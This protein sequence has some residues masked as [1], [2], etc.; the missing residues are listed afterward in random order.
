LLIA[1][2]EGSA[3]TD[4]WPLAWAACEDRL[5]ADRCDSSQAVIVDVLVIDKIDRPTEN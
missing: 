3:D 2:L 4:H 1:P 5:Q